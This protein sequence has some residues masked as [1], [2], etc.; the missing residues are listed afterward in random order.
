MFESCPACA[1]EDSW[2]SSAASVP[3]PNASAPVGSAS[4]A[5]HSAV[6]D[7]SA[8]LNVTVSDTE[9]ITC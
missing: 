1:I 9:T 7:P 5:V 8:G 6:S 4:I 3:P 2:L